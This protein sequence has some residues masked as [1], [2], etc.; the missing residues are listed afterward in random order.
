MN[1]RTLLSFFVTT[2]LLGGCNSGGSGDGNTTSYAPPAGCQM[3]LCDL[4]RAACPTPATPESPCSSCLD[5]CLQDPEDASCPSEC[6][7]ICSEPAPAPPPNP[8]D[9]ALDSC[10]QSMKNTICVDDFTT[11]GPNGE[12]CNDEVSEASCACAY[13]D[14]CTS[15][16]EAAAPACTTCFN[17]ALS[18]AC[19]SVCTSEISAYEQCAQASCA[20]GV[21]CDFEGAPC[22][23]AA[24]TANDC[25]WAVLEDPNDATGCRAA[26][27]GCYTKPACT[28]DLTAVP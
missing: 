4:V 9:T 22:F 12:P 24:K 16:I 13:D 21:A 6:E 14:A 19:A 3:T 11:P 15:A 20:D 18:G 26:A 1:P 10:R 27:E 28:D 7:D 8:C 23:E 5:V 25:F 17:A 2:L